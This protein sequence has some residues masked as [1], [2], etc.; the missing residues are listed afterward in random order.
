MKR[1]ALAILFSGVLCYSLASA[2]D[3]KTTNGPGGWQRDGNIIG[4][5]N[6]DQD[7][8]DLQGVTVLGIVGGGDMNASTYD[9]R[10]IEA[11]AFLFS[12]HTGDIQS[13][14][15]TNDVAFSGDT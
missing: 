4:V 3:I 5:Q 12:S 15:V 14:S 8:V 9:P 1:T 10:G 11:D 7:I 2:V 6:P 13:L